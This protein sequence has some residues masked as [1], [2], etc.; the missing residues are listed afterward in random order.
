MIAIKVNECINRVFI[1]VIIATMLLRL[2]AS[3]VLAV[4]DSPPE[5]QAYGADKAN[6]KYSPLNQINRS[7]VSEL[8]V[9]WQWESPANE[10]AK[11]YP[12]LKQFIYKK[13]TTAYCCL[14]NATTD[15]ASD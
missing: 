14:S 4:N 15:T 12:E 7:N 9:A 5:W 3:A 1:V 11:D 13:Q 8:R 10:V 2:N 6:T